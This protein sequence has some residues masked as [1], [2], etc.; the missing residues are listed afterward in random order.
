MTG[1]DTKLAGKTFAQK[2]TLVFLIV[3][4]MEEELKVLLESAQAAHSGA[5]HTEAVAKSKYD[6]HGLEL[7]YLAGSQFARAAKIEEDIQRLKTMPIPEFSGEDDPIAVG[8]LVEVSV[9]GGSSL[10][11]ISDLGAG[12]RVEWCAANVQVISGDSP[13]GS[14]L[15]G[16]YVGDD[17][18]L[19]S[20]KNGVI[21][22]RI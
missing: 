14:S 20:G 12:R 3:A 8:S 17:I 10:Y 21:T 1:T 4:K 18:S 15:L 9:E 13:L 7:S 11:F 5:T 2:K 22:M 6:T 19:T 16:S